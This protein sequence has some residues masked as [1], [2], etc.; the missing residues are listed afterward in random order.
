MKEVGTARA[1]TYCIKQGW[2]GIVTND[3]LNAV[4]HPGFNN[5]R[6][7]HSSDSGRNKSVW[8]KVFGCGNTWVLK[9]DFVEWNL[10][11]TIGICGIVQSLMGTNV[12]SPS[13]NTWKDWHTKYGKDAWMR[14]ALPVGATTSWVDPDF[15]KEQS[16]GRSQVWLAKHH[17]QSQELYGI[18]R[19]YRFG[20]DIQWLR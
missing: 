3:K 20:R 11:G 12:V 7:V 17:A 19:Q 8:G 15:R 5:V 13:L 10:L 6:V 14:H 4:V 2:T 9:P 16:I 1:Q 18:P